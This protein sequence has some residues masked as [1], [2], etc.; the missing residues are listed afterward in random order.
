MKEYYLFSAKW[1]RKDD[2]FL[3]LWRKNGE[4]YCWR[5]EWAGIYSEEEAKKCHGQDSTFM[6]ERHLLDPLFIEVDY[7]G[8]RIQVV[9]NTAYHRRILGIIKNAPKLRRFAEFTI[10]QPTQ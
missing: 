1:T 5:K 10:P 9:P 6:I 7:E 8:N 4:G 3:T 2:S